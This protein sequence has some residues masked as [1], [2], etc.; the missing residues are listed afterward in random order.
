MNIP[1]PQHCKEEEKN[2]SVCRRGAPPF[3]TWSWSCG[4]TTPLGQPLL[5][6]DLRYGLILFS[7]VFSQLLL[8]TVFKFA[9]L[10]F[11][12]RASRFLYKCIF[13]WKCWGSVTFWCGPRS[14]SADSYLRLMVWLRNELRIRLFSSL[15]LRL[16]KVK[17]FIFFLIAYPQEHYLQ[18]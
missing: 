4:Q 7:L 12:L 13:Q 16:Q 1:D 14:G 6:S 9:L 2:L 5:S 10:D 15:T 3:T 8:L 17:F 18:S 11:R